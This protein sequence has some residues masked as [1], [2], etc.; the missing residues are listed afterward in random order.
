MITTFKNIFILTII[1][2]FFLSCS[3]S[4]VDVV[5]VYV[6]NSNVNIID[7]LV[8]SE[9]GSYEQVL[10]DAVNGKLIFRNVGEWS[11]SNGYVDLDDFIVDRD[12]PYTGKKINS[13]NDAINCSFSVQKRWGKCS[14]SYIKLLDRN[15]YEQL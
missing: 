11:L 9:D 15:Q 13:I 14:F 10:R 3:P 7:T 12:K 4:R 8:L 2:L 6:A 1:T 5:G